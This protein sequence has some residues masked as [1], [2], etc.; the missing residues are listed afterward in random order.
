M[1]AQIE[2]I[3]LCLDPGI[4][5]LVLALNQKGFKTIASCEGSYEDGCWPF[6]WIVFS[7]EEKNLLRLR[8]MIEAYNSSRTD[9]EEH[10]NIYFSHIPGISWL[11]PEYD[12][13]RLDWLQNQANKLAYYI[14][15]L[16]PKSFS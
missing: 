10:W 11:R 1:K 16:G 8:A 13:K 15:S 5:E 3:D 4:K 2:Q 14:T 12:Y 7:Y 6:P 9:K